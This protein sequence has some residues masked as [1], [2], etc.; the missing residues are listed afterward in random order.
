MITKAF[1][2]RVH[3]DKYDEY[4]RRHNPIWPELHETLKAHGVHDY[5]I[6]LDQKRSLLFAYAKIEDESKWD[7]IAQTDQCKR[8]WA[9]MRDIMDTNADNSPVSEDLREVFHID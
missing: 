8:W 3:P 9:Y 5:S 6:F 2:M 4:E 7:A 1:V